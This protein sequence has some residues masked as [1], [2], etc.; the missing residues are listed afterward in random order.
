MPGLRIL[1]VDDNPDVVD[2]LAMVL[3]TMGNNVRTAKD[4]EEAV[5]AAGEFRPDVAL[6]DIGMPKMNGYE[7]A[8][9]IRQQPWGRD[10]ILVA[11]T[12][13]GQDEVRRRSK[14]A[15]FDHHLVKPLDPNALIK[16]LSDWK[17]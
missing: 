6:L 8:R 4:G 9:T 2:S 10:V 7:A 3:R 11:V 1:V 5:R 14:D 12:G 16:Q 17:A 15:G 13:W